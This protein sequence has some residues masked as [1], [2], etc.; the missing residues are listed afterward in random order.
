[1]DSPAPGAEKPCIFLLFGDDTHAMESF[2]HGMI[3]R[4]GDPGMAELNTTHLDGKIASDEDLRTAV[5]SL[6]F[7]GDR[8][9]VILNHPLAR[10]QGAEG[11]K[12]FL[13]LLDEVPPFTALVLLVEDQPF[14]GDWDTLRAGHWLRKWVAEAG[15]RAL[16]RVCGLPT[17]GDMPGWIQKEVRKQGGTISPEA[18]RAL[19]AAVETNTE[20]ATQEITKLLTYVDGKRA[21]EAEDVDLL[22]APMGQGNIFDLVDAA[23][24]GRTANALR[25]LHTLLEFQDPLLVFG[26]LTRQYR[27]LIQAREI[28]DAGGGA[29]EI[30]REMNQRDFVANKL[31]RQA[32]RFSMNDL[33]A[34][35][36]RLLQLD[37]DSKSGQN[38]LMTGLDIFVAGA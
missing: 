26:M 2:V 24:E 12:R 13:A 30:A 19:A 10:T 33:K 1:M 38:D 37:E 18:A 22:C 20:L 7:L 8:R 25:E 23:A 21:V 31:V 36:H 5:S 4:M 3:A 27:L 28:L 9:L 32:R 29:G 35:Y 16:E 17:P 34:V 11:K 15:P 6:P 14:R